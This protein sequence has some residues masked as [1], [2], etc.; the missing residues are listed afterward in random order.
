MVS[1]ISNAWYLLPII[2]GIGGAFIAWFVNKD[3]KSKE[4]SKM[5]RNFWILGIAVGIFYLLPI[6][7]QTVTLVNVIFPPLSLFT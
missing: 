4:N 2:F 1:K 6:L 5:L 3:K 7:G